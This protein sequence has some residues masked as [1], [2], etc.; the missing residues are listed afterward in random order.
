MATH[1][2]F[3]RW[4]FIESGYPILFATM[5]NPWWTVAASLCGLIVSNAN[6]NV[7]TFGVFLKPVTEDLGLS[8]GTFLSGL[9]VSAIANGL[10]TPFVGI[11]LDKNG[12]RK[13]ML[14]GIALFAVAVA[15][16]SRLQASPLAMFYFLFAIV[17]A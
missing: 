13:V 16:L 12:C 2:S 14:P 9:L 11:L 4:A 7:F 3:L 1:S 15:A 10:A 8:R 6:I 5:K 17:G